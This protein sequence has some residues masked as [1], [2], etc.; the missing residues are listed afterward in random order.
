MQVS[1]LTL[2]FVHARKSGNAKSIPKNIRWLIDI[3]WWFIKETTIVIPA[4]PKIDVTNLMLIGLL[5]LE[6]NLS[7]N[8]AI[9]AI[10]LNEIDCGESFNIVENGK[11]KRNNGIR[12]SS[13]ANTIIAKKHVSANIIK[14]R[15][16]IA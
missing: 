13:F 14:M 1:K 15:S 11:K 2:S 12:Y 16:P 6:I 8:T 3:P 4:M 10:E 5:K 9:I 7:T